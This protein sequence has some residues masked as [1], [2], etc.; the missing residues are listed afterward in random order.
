MGGYH[1][2]ILECIKKHLPTFYHG[3]L[4]R[5]LEQHENGSAKCVPIALKNTR[6][7]ADEVD[8]C[9]VNNNNHRS[10]AIDPH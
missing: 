9:D 1:F 6:F 2:P 5:M 3:Q 4:G 8:Q 10:E 7:E